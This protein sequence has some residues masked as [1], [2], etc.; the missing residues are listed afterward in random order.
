MSRTQPTPVEAAILRVCCARCGAGQGEWCV[1]TGTS[2]ITQELHILRSYNAMSAGY[3]PLAQPCSVDWAGFGLDPELPC[4]KVTAVTITL[5]CT[6]G[7][8][9]WSLACGDCAER[10]DSYGPEWWCPFCLSAGASVVA[11]FSISDGV[12]A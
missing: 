8:S 12:T 6:E 7:H 10:M 11:G 5:A 3:L 9:A 4:G 1:V 2:R